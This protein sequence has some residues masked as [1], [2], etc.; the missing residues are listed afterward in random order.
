MGAFAMNARTNSARGRDD[1]SHPARGGSGSQLTMT[2][3]CMNGWIRQ[4]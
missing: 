4:M 3:P 1:S 2:V